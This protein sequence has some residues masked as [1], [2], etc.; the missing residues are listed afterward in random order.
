MVVHA[1]K[2]Q[3]ARMITMHCKTALF[4][5]NPPL[6]LK[7]TPCPRPV[8]GNQTWS[9]SNK[10]P[11]KEKQIL[12]GHERIYFLVKRRIFYSRKK[13]LDHY[14]IDINEFPVKV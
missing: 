12:Q 13:L 2:A 4:I 10:K 9:A 6:R 11:L 14:F 5:I 8:S 7:F 3:Q 1:D